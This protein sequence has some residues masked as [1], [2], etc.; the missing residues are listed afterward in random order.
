MS[1][2]ALLGVLVA[3]PFLVLFILYTTGSL[4]AAGQ[5]QN[6]QRNSPPEFEEHQDNAI[7]H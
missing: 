6:S 3:L 2:K 5:G 7:R 4:Q 1:Y